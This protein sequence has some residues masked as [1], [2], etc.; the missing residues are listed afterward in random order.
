MQPKH[1]LP[2]KG[3]SSIPIISHGNLS[4]FFPEV[5]SRGKLASPATADARELKP[6]SALAALDF[7]CVHP[8]S[9]PSKKLQGTTVTF[10]DPEGPVKLERDSLHIY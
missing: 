1:R 9:I 10:R 6:R 3:K 4:D 5:E 2:T 8:G 7:C